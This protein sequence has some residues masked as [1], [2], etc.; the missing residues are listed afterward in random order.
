MLHYTPFQ[1]A[2]YRL[3]RVA[4]LKR[5]Y[6]LVRLVTAPSYF[7]D[8]LWTSHNFDFVRDESFVRAY[9]AGKQQ[10]QGFEIRWRMSVVLW[11]ARHAALSHGDFVE[12]GVNRG[13]F[14]AA[15]M[16]YLNFGNML[17]R[18]YWLFDTF[19][20]LVPELVGAGERGA[21]LNVYEDCFQFVSSSFGDKPYVRIVR[22][23]IPG[24]LSRF[25]GGAVSFLSIDMNCS[26][27]EKAALEYFWPKM[28]D[29]GVVVLDDYGFAGHEA[30]KA[31]VD[32]F[33]AERSV[34]LLRLPTG[35]AVII[36]PLSIADRQSTAAR[37]GGAG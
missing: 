5:C 33:V 13:F 30:Q 21:Y 14:A 1:R 18:R 27:P 25:Q 17:D 35:Q 15:I 26:L 31:V 19:S 34:P 6:D 12:C 11:A 10:E 8:G 29:G 20:G 36:K 37:N 28:V 16:T 24:T 23:A 22:G 32:E 3:S 7:E 9:L 2:R 4:F